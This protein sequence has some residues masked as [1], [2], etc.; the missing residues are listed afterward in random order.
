MLF[1]N[2]TQRI[3]NYHD[4]QNIANKGS[5]FFLNDTIHYGIGHPCLD[6]AKK[7]PQIH[8]YVWT[9]LSSIFT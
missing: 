5:N 3:L 6:N 2:M 8:K 4:T 7:C 9:S 1:V